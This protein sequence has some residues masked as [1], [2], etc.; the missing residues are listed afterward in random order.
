MKTE[1]FVKKLTQASELMKSERY[2]EALVILDDLKK[3]D[4]KGDFDYN[5]THKLYQLISNTTS[6]YNQELILKTLDNMSSKRISFKEL[7]HSVNNQQNLD[8]DEP[9]LRKEIELLILRGKLE[10]TLEGDNLVFL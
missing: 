8:I 5:L 4:E 3:V 6:L 10:C 2:K 9:N 7:I 1:D